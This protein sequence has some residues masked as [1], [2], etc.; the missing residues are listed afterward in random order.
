MIPLIDFFQDPILAATTL[1]TMLMG[2]ASSL[3]GVLV[4][5]RKRAL[6]GE[7]LSH[8]TY[9]GIVLAIAFFSIFFDQ[10]PLVFPIALLLGAFA[11][12]LLGIYLIYYLES[13]LSLNSDTALCFVL[14]T[15]LGVGV[16]FASKLQFSEPVWFQRVQAILYGQT[17][18]MLMVHVYVYAVLALL[19]LLFIWL[20]YRPLKIIHFD[21]DFAKVSRIAIKPIEFLVLILLVFA[22]VIGIRSVG[23]VLMAG[24]LIAPAAAARQFVTKFW[25]MF[26]LSSFF[27]MGIGFLG[28]VISVNGSIWLKERYGEKISLPAGPIILIIATLLV[29]VAL[30]FER[31]RGLISRIIRRNSFKMNCVE[32]NILKYLSK[33]SKRAHFSDL[34][35]VVHLSLPVLWA[36]LTMMKIKKLVAE[37]KGFYLTKEGEIKA[38]RIIRLHRLWEVYLFT[39]LDVQAENV[40]K[41]AEEM[42]HII[43]PELEEELTEL[44]GDPKKD[45]HNQ[46]IPRKESVS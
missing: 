4:Y 8:A 30:V 23:V 36:V 35:E 40:H 3:V 38:K 2:L 5:V 37:S 19:I 10:S 1:G 12:G 16:L 41:S 22:I 29:L 11:S 25:Q 13:K 42:E 46:V 20:A 34:R 43:S 17:A 15:F 28:I 18:T 26:V 33:L 14:S 32:E 21:Y 27:G 45:P 7:T 6:I 44:L 39:C 31:K 24:M 9:P